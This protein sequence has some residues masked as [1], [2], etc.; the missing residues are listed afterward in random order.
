VAARI[1]DLVDSALVG[2]IA[3]GSEAMANM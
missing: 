1:V 3:A 2:Q